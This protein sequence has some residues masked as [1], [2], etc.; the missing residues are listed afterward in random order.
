VLLTI[1]EYRRISHVSVKLLIYARTCRKI[2]FNNSKPIYIK[3]LCA[4]P[5]CKYTS[6]AKMG[7]VIEGEREE[8][9][10]KG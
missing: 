3:E 4:N 1:L 10:I 2:M 7:I 9:G 6:I 8:K 5:I